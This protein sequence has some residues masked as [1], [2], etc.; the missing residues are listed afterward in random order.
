MFP[1]G[2][3]VEGQRPLR[4]AGKVAIVT[5][6]GSG[7][8]RASALLFSREGASVVVADWDEDS[9]TATVKAIAGG[10]G[11]AIFARTD[12][13]NEDDVRSMIAAAVRAYGRLDVLFNNAGIEG[14]MGVLTGDHSL[15]LWNRVIAVNLTGVFWGA[16][17]RSEM[18]KG[19]WLDRN[20]ASVAGSLASRGSAYCIKAGGAVDADSG[21]EYATQ[22]RVNCRAGRHTPMVQRTRTKRRERR[23]LSYSRW[24]GWVSRRWRRWRCSGQRRASF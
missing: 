8:G 14:E 2:V 13:S 20:N 12:V 23:S 6:G 19:R 4:L 9:G 11:R 18:L 24:A 1:E 15:E 5:G 16:G 17:T 7:I 21:T 3:S 10:G 22:D